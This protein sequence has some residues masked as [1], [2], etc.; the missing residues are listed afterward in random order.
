[1][2]SRKR[3]HTHS[4][5][6]LCTRADAVHMWYTRSYRAVK[7][8]YPPPP[9]ICSDQNRIAREK[10]SHSREHRGCSQQPASHKQLSSDKHIRRAGGKHTPHTHAPER[11]VVDSA[12]GSLRAAVRRTAAL[13]RGGRA[14]PRPVACPA[15][16]W[17]WRGTRIRSTAAAGP[18][19]PAPARW[20][21]STGRA[22]DRP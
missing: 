13:T 5:S 11:I 4:V 6:T 20:R 7:A 22:R 10:T 16:P 18:R 21:S 3:E 9:T 8:S 12:S 17:R 19:P 2:W 14:I 15:P 1:M